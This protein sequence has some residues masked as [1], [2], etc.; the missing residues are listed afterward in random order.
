MK[1]YK[2]YLLLLAIVSGTSA[3]LGQTP[4]VKDGTSVLAAHQLSAY[5]SLS[6]GQEQSLVA[7]EQQRQKSIDS[8]NHVSL[9]AQQRTTALSVCIQQQNRL[10]KAVLT[11]TQLEK[12]T[13]MIKTRRAAYMQQA[14]NKKV[15]VQELP[16]QNP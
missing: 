3:V 9:T 4:P 14:A 13:D 8:I 2:K 11:A 10:I 15:T 5:L 7:L 12:Y 6:S 16:G 1:F